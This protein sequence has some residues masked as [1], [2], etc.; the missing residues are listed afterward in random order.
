M[1]CGEALGEIVVLWLREPVAETLGEGLG[2]P[3]NVTAPVVACGEVLGDTLV[4]RV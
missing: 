2:E 4:V 1:A 3:E